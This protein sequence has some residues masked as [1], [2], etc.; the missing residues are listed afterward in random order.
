VIRTVRPPVN[1]ALIVPVVVV[2][3]LSAVVVLDPAIDVISALV[4][5]VGGE[6]VNGAV[7]SDGV[8]VVGVT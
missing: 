6:V 2:P 1:V 4:S 8:L 3:V 7:V 5:G